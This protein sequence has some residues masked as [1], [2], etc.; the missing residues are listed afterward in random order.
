MPRE[1]VTRSGVGVELKAFAAELDASGV[2]QSG[3]AFTD[4][5]GAD[6]FLHASPE[7]FVIG[8]LF[9]Q[10][11]SA[12]RAWAGPYLLSRRLGHFD[13][14]R[15]A[16][17]RAAVAAAVAAAPALHRFTRTLAGWISDAAERLLECYG[18]DAARIWAGAPVAS[19][20]MERLSAFHGIGRKKAAMVV[21][22]LRSHFGVPM[23]GLERASVAYDTHVRRVFLRAGLSESDSP[24]AVAEAASGVCPA[25][26]GSLDLAA[27]TVGRTW[28]RPTRPR[29]DECRLGGVCPRLTHL[30]APGVG[31]RTA[32]R[33]R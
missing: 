12:E 24:R 11:I 21:E 2:V 10:G 19:E 20:V 33:R 1:T 30:D 9:T 26:P 16:T 22:L 25:S 6:A 15:L 4:V 29:C 8:A 5:P 32:P 3:E 14:R 13:L 23:A 28:C 7:A 27:W 18:G 31:A 17:E